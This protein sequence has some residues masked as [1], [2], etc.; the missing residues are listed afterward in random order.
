M[1]YWIQTEDGR[2]S[3]LF[4]TSAK[5]DLN[6]YLYRLHLSFSPGLSF[7]PQCVCETLESGE[8]NVSTRT[9]TWLCVF[10][11]MCGSNRCCDVCVC[12]CECLERCW[13]PYASAS[14]HKVGCVSGCRSEWK[15]SGSG[16]SLGQLLC[17]IGPPR[18]KFSP[19]REGISN[20]LHC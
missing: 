11:H 14:P 16:F 20:L 7:L 19:E 2:F 12:V 4:H 10:Q 18:L 15:P 3:F 5:E 1:D 9:F 8:Y 17:S 6:V 13:A